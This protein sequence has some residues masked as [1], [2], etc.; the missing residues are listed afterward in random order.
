MNQ[1]PDAERSSERISTEITPQSSPQ[2]TTPNPHHNYSRST[3]IIAFT[4]VCLIWGSTYLGVR[5]AIETLPP[6]LMAG[7]RFTIA[8]LVML[9]WARLSGAAY[10]TWAEVRSASIVGLMLVTLCNGMFTVAMGRV[11]SAIGA[12][13]A[14]SLPIWMVLL[15]WLRPDGK[16]PANGVFAGVVMGF[17]GIV[18]L[19]QPWK[20]FLD[21][22]QSSQH[23]DFIGFLLMF[24]GTIAWAVGSIYARHTKLPSAPRMNTAVQLLSGGLIMLVLAL[25]IGDLGRI[26]LENISLKSFVAFL[27]LIAFG[28]IAAF[29]AY[30]WLLQNVSTALASS[31]TYINPIVALL[32]G[33]TLGGESITANMLIAM[34]II[35]FAVGIIAKYR[36]AQ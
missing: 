2:Q 20:Y 27:Y 12:L 14:T 9:A 36:S 31:Y 18:M 29:S 28:S 7:A 15:D 17:G 5:F 22:A 24:F 16:R 34:V 11:P 6:V 21:D 35:L 1:Q 25:C 13:V 23:F 26:Q 8:G 32:L 4:A 30:A 10:P 33:A 19:V 3:F